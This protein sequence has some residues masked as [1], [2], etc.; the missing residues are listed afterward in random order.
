MG[1]DGGAAI[2]WR[3]R[4]SSASSF[5]QTSSRVQPCS[6]AVSA[7]R[8]SKDAG[9]QGKPIIN[10]GGGAAKLA[11]IPA[12][13]GEIAN[14][15]VCWLTATLALIVAGRPTWKL[16]PVELPQLQQPDPSASNA[17]P[18]SEQINF[19]MVRLFPICLVGKKQWPR[20]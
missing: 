6:G 15:P 2:L 17:Q 20:R 8:P 14:G 7:R 5:R 13:I 19:C 16:H 3:S 12:P 1:A 9:G 4:V 11:G 18:T 10:D